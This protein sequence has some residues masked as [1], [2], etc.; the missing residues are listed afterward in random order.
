MCPGGG[1]ADNNVLKP[2]PNPVWEIDG[3]PNPTAD[4]LQWAE[5]LKKKTRGNLRKWA[6]SVIRNGH[7]WRFANLMEHS[8][9]RDNTCQLNLKDNFCYTVLDYND[10]DYFCAYLPK[11]KA[12]VFFKIAC[13]GD[14][15][16]KPI[17]YR[18]AS[19]NQHEC[20]RFI[21][22]HNPEYAI[23]S[24]DEYSHD[25]TAV[26]V[27]LSAITWSP[28]VF[29]T[30]LEYSPTLVENAIERKEVLSQSANYELTKEYTPQ[31]FEKMCRLKF[32]REQAGE[33]YP[34]IDIADKWIRENLDKD[35]KP[36]AQ[37]AN[38]DT[39]IWE[40]YQDTSIWHN[41]PFE[42]NGTRLRELFD[43]ASKRVT[44]FQ[45]MQDGR[46]HMQTDLDFAEL[47]GTFN[48]K[49]AEKNLAAQDGNPAPD[50]HFKNA[51]TAVCTQTGTRK[52]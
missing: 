31:L 16:F 36:S 19:N 6:R 50:S 52:L 35:K 2:E 22:Q 42:A 51:D 32:Q 5:K 37:A 23:Q 33:K 17:L 18:Y 13:I 15:K 12:M 11:E 4:D 21:A 1:F 14:P 39:K 44:R 20:L 25:E 8:Q 40:K 47:R 38:K 43:F 3:I 48:L 30:A 45:Q 26:K 9:N 24:F 46:M 27:I 28:Q 29:K 41:M 10:F 34:A 49:Q 7:I